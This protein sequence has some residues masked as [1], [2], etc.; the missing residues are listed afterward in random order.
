MDRIEDRLAG[1]RHPDL[2]RDAAE[3][4]LHVRPLAAV[5]ARR[6]ASWLAKGRAPKL[7][8]LTFA[9]GTPS[10]ASAAAAASIIGPG[11]QMK[12]QSIAWTSISRVASSVTLASSISPPNSSI[13]GISSPRT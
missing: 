4:Y 3:P 11:P 1:E 2:R 12:N 9:S 5:F 8:I 6:G 13:S 7:S 10:R